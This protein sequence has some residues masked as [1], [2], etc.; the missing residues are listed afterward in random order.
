MS[1]RKRYVIQEHRPPVGGLHWDLMLEW[2]GVLRTWRMDRGPGELPD[3][4]AHAVRIFDHE[5]RFLEY[6]GPVNKGKGSVRIADRGDF[7]VCGESGESL[8]LEFDGA[9]LMGRFDLRA[10]GEDEFLLDKSKEM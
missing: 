10:L 6:E 5:L 2:D 4:V 8:V 1:E 9:V 3:R 7:E